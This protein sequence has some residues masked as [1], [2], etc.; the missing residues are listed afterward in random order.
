MFNSFFDGFISY[1]RAD[2]KAFASKLQQDLSEAG[3]NMWFDQNDIPLGVDFQNQIDD[4]IEK[5]HNFLYIIAPHSVNSPYCLKEVVLALKRNKPIIPLL[6]VENITFETWQQRNPGGTAEEW[7]TY[8]AAGKH[9]SFP[10]MHPSIGKINW[11]YFRE[12]LDDYQESLKGLI[13]LMHKQEDYVHQHTFLLT[14]ALEWDRNHR[15]TRLLLTGDERKAANKWLSHRFKDEQPPC[16]PTALHCEYICESEKNSNNQLTDVFLSYS[17][18][19]QNVMQVVARRLRREAQ[20]IW[21]NTTDIKTGADFQQEINHGIERADTIVFLISEDS[22]NSIYCQQELEYAAELNKRIISLLVCPTDIE[23]I[24]EKWRSLQ[25]IDIAN[26]E[27]PEQ[28]EQGLTRLI[29]SLQEDS[30]Y[31][32]QHKAILVQAL[33]WKEQDGNASILYRGFNLKNAQSWVTLAAKHPRYPALPIHHEFLEASAAQPPDQSLDVFISYSR[34]DT[35]FARK[36]NEALQIQGKTAWFDQE[37]IASGADFQQEI[38]KGIEQCDN[39]LF[40]IS[41]DAITSE[42]CVDEVEFAASLNKRFVTI[43]HRPVAEEKVHPAFANIQWIDFRRHNGDFNANFSDLIRTL[44]LD[45]DHVKSHTKWLQRSLEWKEKGK[46]KDMLLRGS[47]FTLAEAWLK[48]AEIEQKNPPATELQQGFITKSKAAIEAAIRREK[49]Q[50]TILQG[51]LVLV[52]GVAAIAVIIGVYA[53]KQ[54]KQ[55]KISETLSITTTTKALFALNDQLDAL[56]KAISAGVK[57]KKLGVDTAP[58]VTKEVEEVLRQSVYG[59]RA[60]NRFSGHHAP[61]LNVAYSPTGEYIASAS[62]DNTVKLWTPE[63]ELLQTIEGHN[64]SVLAIAFSPDGKLLATAGVDRVIK[65]WT[66]DGKLVT[67]LIGHLDQI[68][69]LEFSEDSKTIISASSDKTAK[70][71]RVKGG[72]RLV[73]FTGHVDKLNT[74][75]F[76]PSKDMV[77]TGSQDTTIKLWNLE[78]DLLDT[79]EGHTDK[80]TSV[81]FSPNGSHLASVSNDQSI[82]LWDLRTG[83]AEDDV[84]NTDEDHALANRTPVNDVSDLDS[85][86]SHTAPI[87]SVKFSHDG[88]FLVTASDDNTLKIWSIDGYLLTTLAGHTDRVIHLDVHPNDKTIIS[89]SLD[90]TLLVWEWQGSPLLKVLYGHSQAVSGITFNQDGQR[91]Y[92]VAQDGRL[93]EWS[94][95][96]ENPIFLSFEDERMKAQL[97][98]L[99]VSPDGQQVVTGDEEGNMYIWTSEGKLVSTYDAHNDDILAIAFSPDGK[100]FATAGRDKVAKIWDRGGRFITPINGHSDAITDITFSDNGTFIAT[101]SWDNT[102]RAWSREG[103]LL[104]TFDGHEG[105]VLS[106]AIH[107]DSSLIASGS[108]DNTIKI[109]DV[110]NL[111]LQTTI[112]GHHDSVYSVIF[113]PDGETLVSGSGDDRIKLWKPDG[114]FITTYRGHRSDVIDLNFSPDGKQLA[115]GS[116]D[117]TAIIWDVTQKLSL[118][119]LLAEA[120]KWGSG[121]L[122]YNERLTSEDRELCANVSEVSSVEESKND[123][124][125]PNN[126]EGV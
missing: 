60:K 89:G 125:T 86:V 107:P 66:L 10:N 24:P 8:K 68:N 58:N 114:E 96:G 1:G 16:E 82:K 65:L 104:H 12:G 101:S 5:A 4:G 73:T 112:T 23:K 124:V 57:L 38:Y 81:A 44:D 17:E 76:H 83:E 91:I 64:D 118:D 56:K 20:T 100:Q 106:V 87:N 55:L 37:S 22:L 111:E 123:E 19:D 28:Y 30:V 105:S 113:S 72:E 62:V 98:S 63:G 69:S 94:L 7:E 31:H 3:F 21:T 34:A 27:N 54:N 97:V 92:S 50:K 26:T 47:E 116:D 78:G 11:I 95:E 117:N 71:W 115:S 29:K 79:L 2:S 53:L 39:F 121:F 90:N 36:V 9:S 49:R 6:H 41:P 75:H 25:F 122:K 102:V 88:D 67:S 40:I 52:S 48:S 18:H 46:T 85:I 109:W 33:K 126:D 93:K 51:L 77:A 42:Y 43:L 110:N 14:K 59:S 84:S 15:Q 108:G 35:D 13:G 99:A 119:E 45:R 80:V 32:Y 61:I 103:K 120:C 70:L 74:A